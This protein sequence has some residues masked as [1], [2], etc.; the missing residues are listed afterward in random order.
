MSLEQA[1]AFIEKM[2]SDAI[3]RESIFAIADV[4]E[5]LTFINNAGFACTESEIRQM[6]DELT[7]LHSGGGQRVIFRGPPTCGAK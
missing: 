5:R 6:Q 1:H 4:G 2:K 3:F 7:E